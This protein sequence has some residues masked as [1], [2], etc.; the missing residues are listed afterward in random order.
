[1]TSSPP[2][3]KNI[4]INIPSLHEPLL[5][6]VVKMPSL[7]EQGR[8]IDFKPF[9]DDM[10]H[11]LGVPTQKHGRNCILYFDVEASSKKH[12]G[13]MTEFAFVLMDVEEGIIEDYFRS[14]LP[15]EQDADWDDYTLREFWMLNPTLFYNTL[16]Y[17]GI[18]RETTEDVMRALIHW[19]RMHSI[20]KNITLVSD[21]PALDAY[22]MNM[23]LPDDVSIYD[24]TGTFKPIID[25]RS[26]SFGITGIDVFETKES[27]LSLSHKWLEE[28][29]CKK[30]HKFT[31]GD[32]GPHQNFCHSA[33]TDAIR[34]S[35]L[36]FYF[37]HSKKV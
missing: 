30:P 36:F 3:L 13:Q 37:Y 24:I 32:V 5:F 16:Y 27:F 12:T 1:M 23:Y 26:W 33:I 15:V 25:L 22:W 35:K 28:H 4:P 10:S 18:M 9:Q 20:T 8:Y 17:C 19:V 6:P 21:N 14:Y 7:V 34:G 29:K 2:S 31:N 11:E